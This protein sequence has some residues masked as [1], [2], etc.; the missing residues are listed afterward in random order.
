[1]SVVSSGWVRLSTRARP[2]PA[3]FL[4]APFVSK[5]GRG[6]EPG[7]WGLMGRALYEWYASMTCGAT[8]SLLDGPVG[9]VKL[10]L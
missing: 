7:G 10:A 8:S 3:I 6:L 9:G 5:V 2:G 4:G 1:M